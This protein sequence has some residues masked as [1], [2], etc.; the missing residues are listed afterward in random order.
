HRLSS[1][2]LDNYALH[3]GLAEVFSYWKAAIP[4]EIAITAAELS[5]EQLEFWH[6][7]LIKGMGEF[8]YVN[9]IDFTEPDFVKFTSQKSSSTRLKPALLDDSAGQVSDALPSHSTPKSGLP[10]PDLNGCLIP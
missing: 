9:Q 10:E 8:F 6:D 5:S 1:Q 4:E 3:L 7:L 2:T